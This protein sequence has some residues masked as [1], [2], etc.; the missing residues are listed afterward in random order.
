MPPKGL[1]NYS[2]AKNSETET[3]RGLESISEEDSKV[4]PGKNEQDAIES[5]QREILQ[6]IKKPRADVS[7]ISTDI[8]KE[9][10]DLFYK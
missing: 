3:S 1:Q 5:T 8:R 2:T 7:K 9:Y 6:E 4:E 10:K